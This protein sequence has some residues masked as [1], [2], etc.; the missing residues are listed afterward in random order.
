MFKKKYS[1]NSTFLVLVVIFAFFTDSIFGQEITQQGRSK[2]KRL[3]YMPTGYCLEKGEISVEGYL[4]DLDPFSLMPLVG[5]GVTSNITVSG[6]FSIIPEAGKEQFYYGSAQIGFVHK[7]KFAF[8][9]A[10]L[11]IHVPYEELF[12]MLFDASTF[13]IFSGIVTYDTEYFG[14][15]GGVGYGFAGGDPAED[16]MFILGGELK[17]AKNQSILAE[18]IFF[19]GFDMHFLIVG[20]RVFG[21][22]NKNS[23]LEVG[24][25]ASISEGEFSFSDYPHV[26]FHFYF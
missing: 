23:S 9:A 20:M 2:N 22:F 1:F 19:P 15:T 8:S 18:D 16:P 12:E 14:L 17:L 3:F 21:V 25:H 24:F 4:E 13:G 11:A 7:E 10:I 26:G 6:G 5:Y